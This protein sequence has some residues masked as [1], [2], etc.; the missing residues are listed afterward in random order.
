VIV[1][2]LV[3]AG[4]RSSRFGRE[5]AAALVAGRPMIAWVLDVLSRPP[6]TP[7]RGRRPRPLAKGRVA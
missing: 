1:F 5:K 6:S 3:L 2:G 7:G 4:G